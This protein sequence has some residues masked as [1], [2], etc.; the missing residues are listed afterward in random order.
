MTR[1]AALALTLAIVSGGCTRAPEAPVVT[2]EAA[3]SGGSASDCTS[4]T[5]PEVGG[6]IALIDH[7]GRAI[8]EADFKGKPSLVFFGFT[9]CPNICPS[10]LVEM[11]RALQQLPAD[12]PRPRVL[13]ISVDPARDTPEKLAA[14]VAT[15]VFPDDLTGLTG[16]PEAVRAAADAFI[17]DYSRVED[18]SSAAG[19]T[20]DHTTLIYLMDED[21]RL[22]TFFTH[23]DTPETISTCLATLL[24]K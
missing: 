2:T 20:I 3:I 8:T 22:K 18:A 9:Y 23:E 16:S 13:L 21:W 17:A 5:Y 12:V 10:A 7:T 1:A 14:Y 6:A 19:Y 24:K 11:E 15:K 4:R